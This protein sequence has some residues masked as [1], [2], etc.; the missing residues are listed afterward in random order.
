MTHCGELGIPYVTVY[1]FSTENWK[2]SE[3]EVR[4][5]MGYFMEYL[6]DA[7]NYYK[8]NIRI[9]ILG[10]LT[11]F[12]DEMKRRIA[13]CEHDT[14]HA[15]GLNVNVALNYGGQHELAQAMQK[16]AEEVKAG[17]LQPEE[18]NEQVIEDHLYT[19]GMPP[20]DLIIRP[21]GEYRLSNFLIWPGC[22][23]RVCVYGCAVAGFRRKRIG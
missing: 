20:V 6:E 5:L 12:S 22:I 3:E 4:T 1:A 13:V 8:D 21:S 14:A 15:T 18:V 2:R 9:R 17:V 19:K 16:I 7:K 23:R 10:D 11:P